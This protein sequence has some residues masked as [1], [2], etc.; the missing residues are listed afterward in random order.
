MAGSRLVPVFPLPDVVFFPRTTLPLHV[1]ER[2]YRR[3]VEDVLAADGRLAVA[4]LAKG[5]EADYDGS[6]AYH[7]IA[8]IGRIEDLERTPDGRFLFRLVGEARVRLGTVASGTPYRT[9]SATAIP[10]RA[11]DEREASV[12]QANLALLASQGLLVRELSRGEVP[13]IVLDESLSF[14]ET[15]N[16]ICA[17]LPTEAAIRQNLLELDDLPTRQREAARIL[18]ELLRRVLHLKSLRSRDEGP[19]GLN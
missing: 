1:F 11:L 15:L 18:D 6:P 19:S 10:E 3:M 2:R 7:E 8:T 16:G 5:W 13:G 12:R 4:L 17:S 14:E 9:A